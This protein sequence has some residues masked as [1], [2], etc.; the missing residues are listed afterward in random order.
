[1]IPQ[2]PVT[3]HSAVSSGCGVIPLKLSVCLIVS[4]AAIAVNLVLKDQFGNVRTAGS[5]AITVLVVSGRRVVLWIEVDLCDIKCRIE[6]ATRYNVIPVCVDAPCRVVMCIVSGSNISY[7]QSTTTNLG[8][9]S[10]RV[11]LN[12]SAETGNSAS[13]LY[14]VT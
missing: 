3:C 1:M 9:G 2:V 8:A 4:P 11:R 12:V 10:Y 14:F 13:F 5:D 7:V 6:S